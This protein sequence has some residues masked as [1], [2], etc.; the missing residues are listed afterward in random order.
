MPAKRLK[1]LLL[2][3]GLRE[4]ELKLVV[5][6]FDIVGDIAIVKIRRELWDKRRIIAEALM[7]F[8]RFRSVVAVR[9]QTEELFR[10]RGFEVLAGDEDLETVHKEHGCVFKVDLRRVFF[11]PR[12][13]YERQRVAKKV[14]RHETVV[15]MFAGV[16]CFSIA[17]AKAQP[18]AHIFSI[19]INPYAY[20]Y[21]CENVLLNKTDNVIPLLGDAAILMP[22]FRGMADRVLMPLPERASAFLRLAADALRGHG[23]IHYY[24]VSSADSSDVFEKPLREVEE[25]LSDRKIKIEN[26]RVVRS[27]APRKYHV[28][29]DLHVTK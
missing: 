17:I 29:L 23:V 5:R 28:V 11:S 12:L 14:R 19:D 24:T 21:M 22:L 13:S 4:A 7:E 20:K 27:V 3:K 9:G 2:E 1:D 15:N 18:S 25:I 10:T 8:H 16:G 6:A 26:K